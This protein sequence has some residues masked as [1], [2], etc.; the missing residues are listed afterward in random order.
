MWQ[1]GNTDSWSRG[2]KV[3]TC[4]CRVT[5]WVVLTTITAVLCQ[6]IQTIKRERKREEER[7]RER[8]GERE[9]E[10]KRKRKN[11]LVEPEGAYPQQP[12]SATSTPDLFVADKVVNFSEHVG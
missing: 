11:L 9:R 10:R 2:R 1:A 7:E 6:C 4:V 3:Y 5:L 8:G 12:V